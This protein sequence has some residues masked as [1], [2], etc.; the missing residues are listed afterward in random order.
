M[1]GTLVGE[2][3]EVTIV[4]T[5]GAQN[6]PVIGDQLSVIRETRRDDEPERDRRSEAAAGDRGYTVLS[7]PRNLE[8]YKVSFG[9]AGWLRENVTR[10][11]LVHIHALFSFSSTVAARI[12]HKKNVPYIVRP[13]GVLNRWGMQNRRRLVKKLSFQTVDLPVLLNS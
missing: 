6:A 3:V 5:E 11:D 8:A 1:A 4:T 13:L 7:F 12:A 10:F 2:G 9:L